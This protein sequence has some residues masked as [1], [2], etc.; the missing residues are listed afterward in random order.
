M[1]AKQLLVLAA[2]SPALLS[3][4]ATAD[5][6]AAAISEVD[7]T[8]DSIYS[9]GS[10]IIPSSSGVDG[11]TGYGGGG[12]GFADASS[13]SPCPRDSGLRSAPDT[14]VDGPDE[15]GATDA[16]TCTFELGPGDLVIDELM[17]ASQ[18]GAG[19]HGE[20]IE[21]RSTRDCMIDLKGLFASVTHSKAPIVASITDDVLLAPHGF[22]LIA[23]SNEPSINNNLPGNPFV[24]GS[25]TSAD[26]LLNSGD[27][28]TLYTVTTA[29]DTLTYPDSSKLVEGSTMEFPANCS[30]SLR[31]E[32][33]NWQ[34]SITSW[35][36]GFFGTPMSPN[37]DVSCS[38]LPPPPPS[39]SPCDG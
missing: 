11:A 18:S 6:S 17:I 39:S 34:P 27:T 26:V 33:G 2:S 12:Y 25:G 24:W 28:I 1:N 20:W 21:V 8:A 30:P 4:C 16:A 38:V 23:D 35:T 9:G 5:D 3:S 29:I 14:S 37:S 32:F 19:D 15:A 31:T 22:F 36:P 13:L 7:A 10:S